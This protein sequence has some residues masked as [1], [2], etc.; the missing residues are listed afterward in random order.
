MSA[1]KQT[2]KKVFETSITTPVTEITVDNIFRQSKHYLITGD[3]FYYQ[4]TGTHMVFYLRHDGA[5]DTGTSYQRGSQTAQHSQSS[6][7]TGANNGSANGGTIM[8]VGNSAVESGGF[9][10]YMNATTYSQTD[11]YFF[12][13]IGHVDGT[14]Y[15]GQTQYSTKLS[16]NRYDGFQITFNGFSAQAG[17]LKIYE[18]DTAQVEYLTNV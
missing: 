2:Y 6:L 9:K 7:L 10:L 15:R 17:N 18:V 14:G 11:S 16:I 1:F 13:V 8:Y 12:D 5:N 4:T 3:S